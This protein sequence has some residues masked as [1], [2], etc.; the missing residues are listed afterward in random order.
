MYAK[1]KGAFANWWD[2]GESTSEKKTPVA[3]KKSAT[4]IIDELSHELKINVKIDDS[5][6]NGEGRAS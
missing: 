5:P 1:L 3:P 6:P 2:G 4:P